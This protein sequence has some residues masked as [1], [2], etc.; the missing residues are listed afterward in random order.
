MPL[1]PFLDRYYRRENNNGVGLG[2]EKKYSEISDIEKQ[3]GGLCWREL[4][5]SEHL[6]SA[7]NHY[8]SRGTK[9]ESKS[10]QGRKTVLTLGC[11]IQALSYLSVAMLHF[12]LP[13]DWLAVS[14]LHSF[15]LCPNTLKGTSEDYKV[16]FLIQQ[17]E[18]IKNHN[19]GRSCASQH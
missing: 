5:Y 8:K 13:S 7:T 6:C 18:K 1:I 15:S 19:R 17:T 12:L 14:E 2:R 4:G 9:K 10:S 3:L 16:K 11:T